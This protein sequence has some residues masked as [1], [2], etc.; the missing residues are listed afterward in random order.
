MEALLELLQ[1]YWVIPAG[2]AVLVGPAFVSYIKQK[3][4]KIK[5]PK[6]PKFGFGKNKV[7]GTVD[8]SDLVAKDLEAIQWLANRAVDVNDEELILEL[9]NVNKKFFHIHRIMRKPATSGPVAAE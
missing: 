2:A 4:G 5:L 7:V 9:E 1:K 8:L 3:M 6:L